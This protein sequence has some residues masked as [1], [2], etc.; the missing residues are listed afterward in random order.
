MTAKR[1]IGNDPQTGFSK[2]YGRQRISGKVT[3]GVV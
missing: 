1:S 3:P 2:I